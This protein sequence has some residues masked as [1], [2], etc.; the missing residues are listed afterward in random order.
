MAKNDKKDTYQELRNKTF[1]D[2]DKEKAKSYNSSFANQLQTKTPKKNKHHHWRD[3][4]A[5]GTNTTKIANKDKGKMS[6]DLNYIKYYIY[7]E[8]SYYTNKCLKK[9]KNL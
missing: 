5:T 9:L 2:N 3:Q 4:L 8:N 7:Y 6:K 1:K